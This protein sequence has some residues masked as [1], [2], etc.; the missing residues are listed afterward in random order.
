MEIKET[1]AAILV[2]SHKPLVLE[3]IQLPD[4]LRPGQLLVELISSGI[5]GAQINEIDAVKGPDLFLPHLLGHEGYARVIETG[6]GVHKIKPGEHAILHWRPSFGIQSEPPKYF[7]NSRVVNAGWVTTF[8]RHA[9]V[10]ENRLTKVPVQ[11]DIDFAPLLGCSLTT[12]LGVLEND[13][14]FSF[15]DSLLITGFGGVGQAVLR[16]ARFMNAR[17]ITV[18]DKNPNKENEALRLGAN[19]FTTSDGKMVALAQL[20]SLFAKVGSPTVTIETTGHPEMIE[21]CYN[22]SN[23]CGRTVLVG[24]PTRD[25]KAQLYTLPLHLGKSLVGSKG[26]GSNPDKDIPLILNLVSTGE[27]LSS[28]FPTIT[29]DFMQ[30]NEALNQLR[31]G[32]QGRP[33]IRF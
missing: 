18:V 15:R 23:D 22:L 7:L 8:N 14:R 13:A 28:D 24:V 31:T 30:I 16:F 9:V 12:A 2:E 29:F 11:K 26:G 6:P 33:I 20:Q 32:L 1:L 21:L 4:Q 25:R 3:K 5:C 10:S 19:N 17:H 27:L